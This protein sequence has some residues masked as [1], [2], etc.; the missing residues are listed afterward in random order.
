MRVVHVKNGVEIRGGRAELDAMQSFLDLLTCPPEAYESKYRRSYSGL[1]E[2]PT[3]RTYIFATGTRAR[4]FAQVLEQAHAAHH[5]RPTVERNTVRL[6][7]G[8]YDHQIIADAAR[9]SRAQRVLDH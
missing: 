5:L 7:A 1:M 4:A 9:L 2:S 8:D 3:R 6:R